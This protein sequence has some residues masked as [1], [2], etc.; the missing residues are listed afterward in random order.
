MEGE[1]P[2]GRGLQGNHLPVNEGVSVHSDFLIHWTGNDI[3]RKLDPNW[4]EPHLST[5]DQ[6]T[7]DAYLKRLEDI[8]AYGL[9]MT[10]DPDETFRVGDASITVP[11]NYDL[12]SESEWRILYF[13]DLL[14]TRKII[15][16]RDSS[17]EKEHDYFL[18]LSAKQQQR[19]KYLIPVDGWFSMIIYPT[20]LAKNLAPWEQGA[21]SRI[22]DQIRRIK[23]LHDRGNSVE[24]IFHS[25]PGNW[26]IEVDLNA[27]RHF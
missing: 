26:P 3:D 2:N 23:L 1:V 5:K 22:R 14:R 17:N 11:L 12:Y 6:A 25:P 9:W 13:D 10:Q 27:C 7:N 18:S 8:L 20:L 21:G 19:L 4:D 16:P 24:G 15:D